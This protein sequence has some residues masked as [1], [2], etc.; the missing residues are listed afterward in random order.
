[1]REGYHGTVI[2]QEDQGHAGEDAG[3][4]H[5]D[6]GG[7]DDFEGKMV[8]HRGMYNGMHLW[9]GQCHTSPIEHAH[10]LD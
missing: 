5:G 7:S 1:M 4:T 6:P 10:R 3:S 2:E 8:R 9:F